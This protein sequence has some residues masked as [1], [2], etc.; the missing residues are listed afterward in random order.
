MCY[1]ISFFIDCPPTIQKCKNICS[2]W[3]IQ[4]RVP[5][6]SL[7]TLEL[8]KYKK[9]AALDA[10]HLASLILTLKLV[11]HQQLLHMPGL[12][13]GVRYTLWLQS[14]EHLIG[15]RVKNRERRKG[16]LRRGC[17]VGLLYI[18]FTVWF[19][20]KVIFHLLLPSRSPNSIA[21]IQGISCISHSSHVFALRIPL[22][23]FVFYLW[24]AN[25]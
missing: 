21:L 2:L 7:L 3:T 8:E 17:F 5:E 11:S 4:K 19:K 14:H 23:T 22:F 1:K 16:K 12:Q 24:E 20:V 10:G 13:K 25:I 6:Y 15:V 9:K 18:F